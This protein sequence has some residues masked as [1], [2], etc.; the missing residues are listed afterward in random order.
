MLRESGR[1]ER[2]A[3]EK[4]DK[5]DDQ[6]NHDQQFQKKRASLMELFHHEAVKLFRGAQLLVHQVLVVNDTNLQRR[7][8]IESRG[9]HV[10]QEFN[11]VV[12]ALRKFGYFEEHGVQAGSFPGQ[13]PAR[14]K[15]RA[16]VKG[17]VDAFQFARQQVIVVAELE[18]LGVGVFQQLG[19]S[20]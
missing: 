12:G 19:G 5:F 2:L 17:A 13:A 20:L 14:Q 18:E 8:A 9:K 10:A 3:A 1:L 15:P 11:G 4:K 16:A 7:L 6:N